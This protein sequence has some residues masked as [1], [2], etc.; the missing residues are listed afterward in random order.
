MTA[1]AGRKPGGTEFGLSPS[2]PGAPQNG[3]S[4]HRLLFL[5]LAAR[6][7]V[8]AGFSMPSPIKVLPAPHPDACGCSSMVE[9]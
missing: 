2:T 7:Q 1:S 8:S 9:R 6:F 3:A 4:G 5:F